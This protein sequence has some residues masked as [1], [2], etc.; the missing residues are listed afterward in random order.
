MKSVLRY[1][2][3]FTGF[4]L[5]GGG[6]VSGFRSVKYAEHVVA[7]DVDSHIV[8]KM[9]K[10]LPLE[11]TEIIHLAE[12]KVPDSLIIGYIKQE[13]TI[14]QL[15]SDHVSLL[16]SRGVSKM[17]VDY[18]MTTPTENAIRPPSALFYSPPPV[19]YP[20][21]RGFGIFSGPA[22]FCY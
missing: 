20:Y 18:M 4:I 5:F 3:C 17:V 22:Y 10:R 7:Y 13:Q 21:Y 19:P 14:Y 11:L 1:L 12:R 16:T 6:C 15:N 2:L 9:E 8:E